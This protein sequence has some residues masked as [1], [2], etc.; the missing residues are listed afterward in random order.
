M[1]PGVGTG[2]SYRTPQILTFFQHVT[3]S[4]FLRQNSA[5]S[6]TCQISWWNCLPRKY[7][8]VWRRGRHQDA[9][10]GQC[11][12]RHQQDHNVRNDG[13]T[14]GIIRARVTFQTIGISFSTIQTRFLSVPS[15][16]RYFTISKFIK[17]NFAKLLVNLNLNINLLDPC[18]IYEE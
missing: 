7:Q 12:H 9:E 14:S 10:E 17:V 5:R 11:R 3:K 15:I 18:I 4:Q 13:D 8:G 16:Q 6:E 2:G 1:S